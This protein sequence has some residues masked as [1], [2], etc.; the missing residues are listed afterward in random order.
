MHV[1][2]QKQID[3]AVEK[4]IQDTVQKFKEALAENQI[5]A[6]IQIEVPV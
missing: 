6:P 2:F 5:R 4:R 1:P 3:A